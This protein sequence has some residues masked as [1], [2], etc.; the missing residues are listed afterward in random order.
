M[1]DLEQEINDYPISNMFKAGL[2]YY[3]TANKIK[4]KNKK[5]LEKII[6]EFGEM[7]L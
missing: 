4:I 7:E 1:K 3:L 5:E 6:K 2:R